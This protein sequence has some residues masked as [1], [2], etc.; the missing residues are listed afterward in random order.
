MSLG[1]QGLCY[2]DSK[3]ELGKRASYEHACTYLAGKVVSSS[4]GANF[5]P[6]T[7]NIKLYGIFPPLDGL[8]DPTYYIQ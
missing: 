2:V 7:L 5:G 6:F 8:S 4:C 1:F 3:N